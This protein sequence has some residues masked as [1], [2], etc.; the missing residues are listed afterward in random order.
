M[1]LTLVILQLYYASLFRGGDEGL[2]LKPDLEAKQLWLSVGAL[3]DH[4]IPGSVKDN[5]W[6]MGVN[7]NN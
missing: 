7:T 5:F 3:E 1:S 4:I 2:G 6:E